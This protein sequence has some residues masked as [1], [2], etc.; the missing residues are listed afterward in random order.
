[1]L[2]L[3]QPCEQA[4]INV[5]VSKQLDTPK[6]DNHL[7]ELWEMGIETDEKT[8]LKKEEKNKCRKRKPKLLR[9]AALKNQSK[10]HFSIRRRYQY[11]SSSFS[12]KKMKI[13][14]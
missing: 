3:N 4:I 10:F 2:D 7:D 5:E 1:M 12:I 6:D 8:K 11:D 14:P 13:S 9:L